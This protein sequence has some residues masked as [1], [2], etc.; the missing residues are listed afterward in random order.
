VPPL[1][2]LLQVFALRL[3]RQEC[4]ERLLRL[5]DGLDRPFGVA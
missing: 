5:E 2:S 4:E 1:G 3:D